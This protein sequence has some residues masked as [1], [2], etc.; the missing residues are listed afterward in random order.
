MISRRDL[1]KLAVG[2]LAMPALPAAKIDS[3]IH[4]IH[5]GLQTYVFTKAGLP[6]NGLLDIA[7]KSMVDA[8]LGECDLFAPLIEP[9][10][11]WDKI[12]GSTAD[13]AGRAGARQALDRWRAAVSLDFYRAIR[14]K[15][16]EAGIEIY[17]ISGF[18]AR[19][20]EELER[21]FEI[22]EVLGATLVT[23][24][25]TLSS[26]KELA[27]IVDKSRFL[28]GLQGRPDMHPASPDSIST[29]AQFE[30][31]LA[32]SNNYWL[33]FDIGDATGGGYDT[34]PFLAAH[35]GR[36]ALIYLKDRRKDRTSVPWG[37]GNTPI[38]DVLRL[39]RDRKYQWRCFVDC[40]YKT[41]DRPGDVKRS[42]EY[43]KRA[44]R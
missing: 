6:Q 26:A 15:I 16:K 35:H 14:A 32:L 27:P 5:F 10:E 42:F 21:V 33:S 40:D 3:N 28:V 25:S 38:I 2:S 17:G 30:E 22:A 43:A 18:P 19:T 37:D 31:A 39:A 41:A 11:F 34:L 23:I 8:S 36:I 1:G 13:A 24:G 44:L 7:I 4:G 29:P 12:R 9:A 20:E